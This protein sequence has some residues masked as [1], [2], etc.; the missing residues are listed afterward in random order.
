MTSNLLSVSI[1]LPT[2]EIELYNIL[3]F[4]AFVIVFSIM[5]SKLIML[6]HAQGLHLFLWL[7]NI[8]WFVNTICYLLMDTWVVF[9]FWT[10]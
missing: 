5:F 8:P 10:L 3:S 6:L 7:N 4:F 1:N 9:I 2:V